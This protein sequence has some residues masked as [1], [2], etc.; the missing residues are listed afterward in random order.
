MRLFLWITVL[1]MFVFLGV[2]LIFEEYHP[3][4]KG[5][6]PVLLL[7]WTV[8]AGAAALLCDQVQVLRKVDRKHLA[9]EVIVAGAFGSVV[10]SVLCGLSARFFPLIPMLTGA[11]VGALVHWLLA[12]KQFS[13]R[14]LLLVVL[15]VSVAMSWFTEAERLLR[16]QREGVE[17][18]A[19]AGKSGGHCATQWRP[20]ESWMSDG[21]R[22]AM[23]TPNGFSVVTAIYEW[24]ANNAELER[25]KPTLEKQPLETLWLIGDRVTDAGLEHLK[26]LKALECLIVESNQLTGDGL[27]HLRGLPNLKCLS[28]RSPEL[29]DADLEHVQELKSLRKLKVLGRAKVTPYGAAKLQAALPNCECDLL[30]ER[31]MV[32]V[33]GGEP[34]ETHHMISPDGFNFGRVKKGTSRTVVFTLTNLDAREVWRFEPLAALKRNSGIRRN[35]EDGHFA[36]IT[37][38]TTSVDIPPLSCAE[39]AVTFT[40]TPQPS[41]FDLSLFHGCRLLATGNI[42][43]TERPPAKEIQRILDFIDQSVAEGKL[44]GRGA[45]DFADARLQGLRDMLKAADQRRMYLLLLYKHCDGEPFPPDWVEGEAKEE[46]ARMLETESSGRA[47]WYGLYNFVP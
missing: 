16:K 17:F 12:S 27:R 41:V 14:S 5:A 1:G 9:G 34:I 31:K 25:L 4:G 26:G 30:G 20:A 38:P 42:A 22:D 40:L 18:R 39:V 35:T 13:L 15:L 11:A 10:G 6:L 32:H 21:L 29:S 2:I 19:E 36:I 7:A 37:E 44:G 3:H 47:T 43:E 28:F 33:R 46:L 8:F 45:G 24:R 23:G